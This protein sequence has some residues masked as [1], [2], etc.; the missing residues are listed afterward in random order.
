MPTQEERSRVQVHGATFDLTKVGREKRSAKD[1]Q[2]MAEGAV[3][4]HLDV[5]ERFEGLKAQVEQLR[6]E[7]DCD[8]P[9]DC[10]SMKVGPPRGSGGSSSTYVYRTVVCVCTH[11]N[12]RLFTDSAREEASV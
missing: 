2:I 10:W 4:R 9:K 11:C 8:H 3:L 7:A 12:K 5:D 1:V 6:K